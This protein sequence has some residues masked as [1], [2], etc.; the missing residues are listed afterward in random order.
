[1]EINEIKNLSYE[2]ANKMRQVEFVINHLSLLSAS[3]T[4][5][6]TPSEKG[7]SLYLD[8]EYEGALTNIYEQL[9]EATKVMLQASNFVH[10][11]YEKRSNMEVATHE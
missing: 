4:K 1:M 10:E 2:L 5:D 3:I 6:K 11:E 8:L 7:M 9:T